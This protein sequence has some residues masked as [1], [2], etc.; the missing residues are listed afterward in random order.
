MH[1]LKVGDRIVAYNGKPLRKGLRHPEFKAKMSRKGRPLALTLIRRLF[2]NTG[3]SATLLTSS[4][5]SPQASSSPSSPMSTLSQSPMSPPSSS[6]HHVVLGSA[7]LERNNTVVTQQLDNEGSAEEEEA[8]EKEELRK[9]ARAVKEKEGRVREALLASS[10]NPPAGIMSRGE[11]GQTQRGEGDNQSEQGVSSKGA[12][13]AVAAVTTSINA[14]TGTPREFEGSQGGRS[15]FEDGSEDRDTGEGV[16]AGVLSTMLE[17]L[18]LPRPPYPSP[19]SSSLSRVRAGS[20]SRMDSFSSLTSFLSSPAAITA[21]NGASNLDDDVMFISDQFERASDSSEEEGGDDVDGD[22]GGC[23]SSSD[24]N[25]KSSAEGISG[26]GGDLSICDSEREQ[27]SSAL[28]LSPTSS[29]ASSSTKLSSAAAVA[30]MFGL[31]PF[32]LPLSSESQGDQ[33][34]ASSVPSLTFDP[35]PPVAVPPACLCAID[36]RPHFMIAEVFEN[37]R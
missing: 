26:G 32:P 6:S 33:Q 21:G 16:A 22:N 37:Q 1:G 10:S 7:E 2:V 14:F 36:E 18:S 12:A 34:R 29:L 17:S 35:L 28:A 23:G 13:A 31:S 4:P 9:L 30:S 15:V 8:E 19:S 20:F 25:T 24:G 11:E 5:I 3:G 27:S